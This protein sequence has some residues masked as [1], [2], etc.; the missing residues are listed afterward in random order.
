MDTPPWH[1]L[2]IEDNAE[3]CA[4]MRQ[5]L[6]RGGNRRYRFSEARLGADGVHQVLSQPQGPVDCVL[7][8]HGLPDMD[9]LE[10]LAALR[11][12]SD[13]PPCPVVV[14]TGAVVQEGQPLLRAGAQDFIGKRWTSA[15]SLTRAVENAVDRYALQLQRRRADEALRTSEQHYRA[16]FNSIDAGYAVVEVVFGDGAVEGSTTTDAR[17]LQVNPA[18]AVQ[19]G[20]ANAQGQTWRALVPGIEPLW[21]DALASVARTGEPVRLEEFSAAMQRWFDMHAFRLGEPSAHQVVMLLTDIT[22]RKRNETALISAKL[23]AD[24]ASR[25]KSDFLLNMSHELRSPLS[26]I[27]GFTQLIEAS[28]PPPTPAQQDSVAQILGAG[29]YLLGLINEILDLTAIE[30]GQLVLA[31]RAVSLAEVLAD[32]QAMVGPQAQRSGIRIGFPVLSVP[33]LVQ[34]DPVRTKQVL[35]NLLSNAIKYNRAAGQVQVHCTAAPGQPVRISVEDTGPGLSPAQLGQLFE[36]FNRLGQELGGEPGTGIGLVIC[37]RLVERMGGRMGAHSTPGV[38]SCFW[39]ELD[40]AAQPAPCPAGTPVRTV[41]CIDDA[42]SSL[43]QVEAL[44][45]QCPG[46]CL[47][48]AHDTASGLAIAR[49][50]RPDMILMGLHLRDPGGL[51]LHLVLAR[52]PAT[53]HIPLVALGADG[54]P[55]HTATDTD[56]EPDTGLPAGFVGRLAQPLQRAA[57]TNLLDLASQP[58]QPGG[59]RAAV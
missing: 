42:G 18:F 23:Q 4:D 50:A 54:G 26:A 20:L 34:A 28:K 2:L 6:L 30:S 32:C 11:H 55:G 7:L 3:D 29:W 53:A 35:L 33:C 43:Q 45:A 1:I 47:L 9:A 25:A 22:A 48:R 38:G 40:A 36:P 41:L 13:M 37:K 10:V 21:F 8:D 31:P 12:G 46:T 24:A 57:F 5:M 51:H 58:R 15:D 59:L 39:F 27:L 52:D 49:T 17:C 14:I 56:T 19:T 44:L 16:L